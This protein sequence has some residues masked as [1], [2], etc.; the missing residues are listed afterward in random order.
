MAKDVS[1]VILDTLASVGV[2]Q[3]FGIPGDA[4]N[5]LVDAVRRQDR[6]EFVTVR[7]EEAGAFAASAQAKLTGRLGVVVG[8]A[9]P[10]AV[11][12]PTSAEVPI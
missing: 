1:S 7:H 10:G 9:G 4:I 8:T 6:I 11:R 2:R 3:I 12:D 5:G